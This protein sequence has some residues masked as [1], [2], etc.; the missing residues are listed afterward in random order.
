M[1]MLLEISMVPGRIVLLFFATLLVSIFITVAVYLKWIFII[2]VIRVGILCS[3][4]VV[5][6]EVD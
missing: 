4:K 2:L 6:F 5:G 1:K 3:L